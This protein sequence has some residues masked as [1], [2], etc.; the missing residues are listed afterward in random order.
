[1]P[2]LLRRGT[3][4]ERLTITP[5]EGELIYTTDTKQLFV[6]DGVSTGGNII[7]ASLSPSGL[8]SDLDLNNYKI[9]GTGNI[10]ITGSINASSGIY[11]SFIGD[12]KGSVFA[13]DSTQLVDS[14]NG[15]LRGDHYGSVY[16]ND[17]MTV[18]IDASSKN[19]TLND[20][21]A[22]SLITDFLSTPSGF[23]R[24]IQ[25]TNGE[26]TRLVIDSVDNSGTL[27]LRRTSTSDISSPI[28]TYGV[29]HFE[30]DDINGPLITAA[31]TGGNDGIYL[32]SD[33][34]GMFTEAGFVS[35]DGVTHNF[36]IGTLN[37]T[38]K[39]DVRGSGIFTDQ[40]TASAFMG[41]LIAE[42]SSVIIN[43]STNTVST[44]TVNVSDIIN[45]T[46]LSA[47]PSGKITGT[48]AM[49]DRST[50]DPLSKGSG[51]AYPV[52]Y[53]GSAWAAL[54]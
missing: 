52:Y 41:N 44:M 3:N 33:H 43:A 24:V 29:I 36:G 10:D 48:I 34:D 25:P 54:A 16:A 31:M 22:N 35:L 2:L 42:D 1:M 50:W 9:Y 14:V 26:P 53:T 4:A 8:G 6:G 40:V 13:D 7:S 28:L 21:T 27:K 15:I 37:P 5:L 51:P 46:P 23:L 38:E 45:L 30:R 12:L 18:M 49:A 17:N 32:V 11:G 20:I 39:L 47:E 19:A